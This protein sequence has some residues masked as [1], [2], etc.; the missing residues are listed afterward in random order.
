MALLRATLAPSR[1]RRHAAAWASALAA[2]SFLWADAADA[3]CRSLTKSAP[4]DF[5]AS[6]SG[7][8]FDGDGNPNVKPL[9]WRNSCVGYSIHRPGSRRIAYEDVARNM[10]TAFTRWTGASCPTDGTGRS[11]PSIDVRDLGPVDCAKV[12][13]KSG[14]ANQ[15]VVIFRDDSWPEEY[16]GSDV[17]GLT[18]VQYDKKTGEIY[19]ADM[20]L[21][22]YDMDPLNKTEEPPQP[23]QYDFLSVVTHEAGHFLGFAH[24]DVED[25][26]MYARYE[27][28]TSRL[29][30]LSPDDVSLVCYVYRPNGERA[31]FEGKVTP[32]PQCDPTPRGGYTSECLE[33]SKF[34]CAVSSPGAGGASSALAWLGAATAALALARRRRAR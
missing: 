10:S 27:T 9:F 18:F 11:R 26:T 34:P 3:Y 32:G 1:A 2:V 20:E 25:A 22:T 30:T 7:G 8:C 5:D 13:Y 28:G 17:L 14:V 21:N 24:S 16:G 19:G 33:K 4:P 31:V 6:Q 12:A 29:R 15:N 23:G